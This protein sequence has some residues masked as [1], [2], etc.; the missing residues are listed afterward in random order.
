[1]SA[2]RFRLRFTFW[3]DMLKREEAEIADTIEELKANREFARTIREGIQLITS[4]R[5]GDMELLI[6]LFE[7]GDHRQVDVG[8]PGLL[9]DDLVDRL[10]AR[11]WT[12][13]ERKHTGAVVAVCMSR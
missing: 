10:V 5:E 11:G 9:A 7:D 4:L 8:H 1:M 3:L 6:E 13:D 12:L 2:E